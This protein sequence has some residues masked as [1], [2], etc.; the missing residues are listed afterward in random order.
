MVI[1]DHVKLQKATHG[2]EMQQEK[3]N[4]G[5]CHFQPDF[6]PQTFFVTYLT[7]FVSQTFFAT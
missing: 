5:F 1:Q 3:I 2:R 7:V 4:Q 6:H